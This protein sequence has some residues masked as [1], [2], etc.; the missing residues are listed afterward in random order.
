MT[1]NGEPRTENREFGTGEWKANPISQ[2]F[3]PGSLFPVPGSRFPVFHCLVERSC[4][5]SHRWQ[6]QPAL[7]VLPL[8]L[9]PQPISKIHGLIAP[10]LQ[11]RHQTFLIADVAI[12]LGG[13]NANEAHQVRIAAAEGMVPEAIDDL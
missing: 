5:A 9:S 11:R 7:R 10:F 1:E 13:A 2:F 3:I 4:S 8:S 6:A 12:E